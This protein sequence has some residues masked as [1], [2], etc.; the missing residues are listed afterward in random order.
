VLLEQLSDSQRKIS[1]QGIDEARERM[2]QMEKEQA[3]MKTQL[4]QANLIITDLKSNL[5][6]GEDH[7]NLFEQGLEETITA[8]K[9]FLHDWPTSMSPSG[10]CRPRARSLSVEVI[11]PIQ[12]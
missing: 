11:S 9:T 8:Q 6:V 1:G 10:I 3:E 4:L 7:E 12:N 5:A 2:K